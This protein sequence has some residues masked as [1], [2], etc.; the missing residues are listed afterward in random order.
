MDRLIVL[1]PEDYRLSR[2][3]RKEAEHKMI[4]SGKTGMSDREIDRFVKYFWQSLHPELF[5]KPLLKTA[6]L[7][8]EIKSDRTLARIYRN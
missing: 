2:Q 3:W 8:V 6:D 4:A 1:S 5:I 7:V